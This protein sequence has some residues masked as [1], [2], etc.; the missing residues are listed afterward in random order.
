MLSRAAVKCQ[1]AFGYLSAASGLVMSAADRPIRFVGLDGLRGVAAIVVLGAHVPDPAL[2]AVIPGADLAVDLFFVLSGFVLAQAYERR[3][4]ESMSF[5]EFMKL[6]VV[7]LYPLYILGTA[8]TGALIVLKAVLHRPVDPID[9]ILTSVFAA[10]FLPTPSWA[11]LDAQWLYP[12][13]YPAWS[14][15]FELF[16]NVLFAY[17]VLA[18][19]SLSV[20]IGFVAAGLAVS[21]WFL[22]DAGTFGEIGPYAKYWTGGFGRVT[23]SFFSGLLV[24][25]IWL[26]NCASRIYWPG[27]LSILILLACLALPADD[28]SRAGLDLAICM[29][30]YPL[31][32]LAAARAKPS[33]A[34]ARFCDVS[35]R[36]SYAFYVLQVPLI[37]MAASIA[38]FAIQTPLVAFGPLA[39]VA[40]ACVLLA[41]AA[42]ADKYYDRPVR[43]WLGRKSRAGHDL[44]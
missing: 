39:T 33:G 2:R 21:V 3:L 18:L 20:L 26:S 13:N 17:F 15:F 42:A 8:I 43:A 19:R 6:R 25:R 14:L 11:S 9:F 29:G 5:F 16:A 30:V 4:S 28:K 34:M 38:Q 12:L 44:R 22:I 10:A 37:F 1:N 31:I 7:R 41:V 36:I 32:V 24:Y 27:W 35:G 23:L 40:I